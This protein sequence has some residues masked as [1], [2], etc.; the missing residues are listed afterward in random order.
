MES[1]AGGFRDRLADA[2]VEVAAELY[3]V[4]VDLD[5]LVA[6]TEAASVADHVYFGYDAGTAVAHNAGG[7]VGSATVH[8]LEVVS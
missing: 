4:E 2:D 5:A 6:A 1:L 7:T 3:A 8:I